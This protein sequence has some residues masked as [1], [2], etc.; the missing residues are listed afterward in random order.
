[1]V[2]CQL[3]LACLINAEQMN[4]EGP[5]FSK[6]HEQA[7]SGRGPAGITFPQ[8]FRTPPLSKMVSLSPGLSD[9]TGHF[10]SQLSLTL[11]YAWP[12]PSLPSLGTGHV[13]SQLQSSEIAYV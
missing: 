12:F 5:V 4:L 8:I 1:M 13:Y 3:K 7:L 2:E 11:L 6:N 10:G 9:P